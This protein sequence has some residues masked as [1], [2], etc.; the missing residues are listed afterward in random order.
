[1]I[2]PDNCRNSDNSLVSGIMI[3]L[4]GYIRCLYRYNISISTIAEATGLDEEQIRKI[5]EQT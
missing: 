3:G 1:M 4:C 5:I 2:M